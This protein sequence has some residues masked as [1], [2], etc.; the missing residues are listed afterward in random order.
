MK[1]PKKSS[2]SPCAACLLRRDHPEI[3]CN[4]MIEDAARLIKLLLKKAGGV[5]E[6]RNDSAKKRN[7]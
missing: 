7:R 4:F 6:K 1:K 3:V 5:S 2:K